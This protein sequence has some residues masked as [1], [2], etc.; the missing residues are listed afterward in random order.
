MWKQPFPGWG[1]ECVKG[2][3]TWGAFLSPVLQ[4]SKDS[5]NF[6]LPELLQ[7]FKLCN[8]LILI[9]FASLNDLLFMFRLIFLGHK[10]FLTLNFLLNEKVNFMVAKRHDM[11]CQLIG[12]DSCI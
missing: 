2:L 9:A 5:T 1:R 4:Q 12:F 6:F 11:F 10:I 3:R 8:C 7:F